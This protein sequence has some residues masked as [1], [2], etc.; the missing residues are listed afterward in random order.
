MEPT[1]FTAFSSSLPGIHLNN[2]TR[3]THTAA[4]QETHRSAPA[5]CIR[6][7]RHCLPTTIG[8]APVPGGTRQPPLRHSL[9]SFPTTRKVQYR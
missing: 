4:V 2:V 9:V 6:R 1:T 5:S 3:C 8:D 7:L